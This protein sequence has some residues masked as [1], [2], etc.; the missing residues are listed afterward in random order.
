MIGKIYNREVSSTQRVPVSY[1]QSHVV[2]PD[3][4]VGSY[5][6]DLCLQFEKLEIMSEGVE[7]SAGAHREVRARGTFGSN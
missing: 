4:I 3:R 2:L 5:H 6:L 1:S 7:H